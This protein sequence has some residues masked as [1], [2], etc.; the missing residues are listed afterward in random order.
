MPRY[1]TVVIGAGVN[2]LSTCYQLA[3]RGIRNICLLEQFAL[4]HDR[5]SSHGHSR[6]TR[7]AYAN[8]RYV[9][10]MQIAHN[11]S[12]PQLERDAGTQ[13]IYATGGCFFGPPNGRFQNY[14]EA[15]AA[16]GA[17][18]ELLT[19]DEGRRRF[20]MF[21][22]GNA[23]GVLHDRT[24]ALVAAAKTVQALVRLARLNG[25]EIR[26]NTAVRRIDHSSEPISVETSAGTVETERL[27]VTAGPWASRILPII[28][29]R[30]IVTRQTVGY[31]QLAG[32]REHFEPG[33]FPVWGNLGSER[34][35]IY[36]G[37]PQFGREGVKIAKHIVS[38]VDDDPDD[39]PEETPEAAIDDLRS[40]V[41]K[42]FAPPI[43]RFVD[44]ETCLYT[45]TATEDFILDIHPD[46]PN[47]VIGAGFSGHG[48]KFGPLTGRILCEL[49][50]H[51]RTSLPEFEDARQLFAFLPP[52]GPDLVA[53]R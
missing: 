25:V 10:L 52:F 26:E 41:M 11:E 9:R 7:S 30:V 19:V 53:P 5:G 51:G 33:K 40:Y 24:A 23:T 12:W 38:G 4:A 2:G 18:V 43:E 44:W 15:V 32:P 13:L 28:R 8:D 37:L 29:S 14:A 20:P 39:V 34:D 22:F 31:F 3:S 36:Y 16:A 35:L 6:V 45:C 17:D 46:N 1:H 49:S 27:I 50:L 21:R 42:E 47:V 48:F